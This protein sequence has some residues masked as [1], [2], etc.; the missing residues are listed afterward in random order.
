MSGI[1][2]PTAD[3]LEAF[4]EGLLDQ[5]E[6]VVIESH[7]VNCSR[8]AGAGR[9]MAGTVR[10]PV[11]AAAVH[12]D[13]RLRGSRHGGSPRCAEAG[14][15]EPAWRSVR[16]W[17][18]GQ[19]TAAGTAVAGVLPKSTFGWGVAVAFLALPVLAGITFI[20]WLDQ[21]V[22]PDPRD[23]VGLRQHPG[24]GGRPR[25]G[26]TAL[27][28]ALQTDVVAWLVL[29]AGALLETAGATGVGAMLAA[30]SAATFFSVWVLYRNLI[31]TPT[32]GTNYVTF[33][34]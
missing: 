29:Q 14:D 22:V 33:S 27:T 24:R 4:A 12:A 31:R 16:G 21:P 23:A 10:G 9:G 11:G 6:R 1:Y 20:A 28:A 26:T 3:R 19:A 34:F 7:V 30:A 17:A 13:A 25:L 18:V 5:G 8:C 2:H 32:R 15:G